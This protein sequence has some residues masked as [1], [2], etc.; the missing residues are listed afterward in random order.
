MHRFAESRLLDSLSLSGASVPPVSS[1]WSEAFSSLSRSCADAADLSRTSVPARIAPTPELLPGIPWGDFLN[2]DVA[3]TMRP[4]SAGRLWR[5][6]QFF[7]QHDCLARTLGAVLSGKSAL[8]L[9]LLD[10]FIVNY[11]NSHSVQYATV[12]MA[13]VRVWVNVHMSYVLFRRKLRKRNFDPFGRLPSNVKGPSGSHD[14]AK[15]DFTDGRTWVRTTLCQL[16]CFQWLV[17]YGVFEKAL[18]L[19]SEILADMNSA[20]EKRRAQR[21]G[22]STPRRSVLSSPMQTVTIVPVDSFEVTFP[23]G[24]PP[25]PVHKLGAIDGPGDRSVPGNP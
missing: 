5:C 10:W 9:R 6:E 23:E 8:S 2:R 15:F 4:E 20:H 7:R 14:A 19:R 12:T 22:S 13:G 17:D 24:R 11:S 3:L 1:E 21:A 25:I 16:L 18:E